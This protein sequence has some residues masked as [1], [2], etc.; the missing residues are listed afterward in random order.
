MSNRTFRDR[1]ILNDAHQ[2]GPIST[3][4]A[5]FRLSGPGWLLSAI[6]LGSG[7]LVG[8]LY[9]GMLGGTSML[10]LQ[11]VAIVI[12]VIMLSAIAYVTLSTR[13]RPYQAVNDYVN[14]VLGVGWVA[15]TILANMIWIMPQFSLCYD[16]LDTSLLKQPIPTE[17]R[18]ELE[19]RKSALIINL[20]NDDVTES[21][22]TSMQNEL[23]TINARFEQTKNGLGKEDRDK[24]I[25]SAIIA[26]IAFAFVL[27]SFNPGWMSKTFDLLLKLI[28]GMIVL[29]FVG[30]VVILAKNGSLNW[31]EI[32][33]GFIPDFSQWN[34]PAPSITDLLAELK[35]GPRLFWENEIVDAQR[36]A[37]I[38]VTA[39]AV[40]LNMTFMLPYSMLA[41][42]WDK[43]FRGLARFELIT[44]MAIPYI[45][46]TTCIVI[47]SAYAFHAKA[48]QQLL[49]DD[50]TVVVE[51]VMFQKSLNVLE[52]RYLLEYY[53]DELEL[54]TKELNGRVDSLQAQLSNI[55]NQDQESA[56]YENLKADLKAAEAEKR[57][58]LAVFTAGL[59]ESEKRIAPTTIKPNASQFSATLKLLLGKDY[60]QYSDLIF[61]LGAFAMGFS[62]IVILSLINSLAF[63]EIV[64][65]PNS[66][67]AKLAGALVAIIC[68]FLWFYAW[69]GES[70]TWLVVLASTF[71]AILLPIAYISF[72]ALMNN[73]RL[74]GHNK[75]TGTRMVIW[76]VLMAIG[77][78]GALLQAG[79]AIWTKIDKPEGPYVIGGVVVFGLLALV[80]FSATRKS[81]NESMDHVQ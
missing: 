65:R 70:Q 7:S 68:G 41:R 50:P 45:V 49:S 26:V 5:Y 74:L 30:V 53:D 44:A 10:W 4:F 60:E 36:A 62:T 21:D 80:G 69:K 81:D 32:W 2:S 3:L 16:A 40:G 25:A 76:N 34:Q 29:C 9:L 77:C 28:V 33:M 64:G 67:W 22:Q 42:G 63:S 12:G 46:V 15:A 57:N 71:G 8:A 13:I 39:T 48:D 66:F 47:A 75:P 35:A 61:G 27:M 72:F 78:A 73:S 59:T 20:E 79:S 51:S 1:E 6:T 55:A 17:E 18:L 43:P 23:A 31:S 58:K 24:A 19:Q 37:M 52:K 56:A 38:G 54:K 14:P 11:L